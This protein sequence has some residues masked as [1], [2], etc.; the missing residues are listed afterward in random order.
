MLWVLSTEIC[1]SSV[2]TDPAPV[3]EAS[4]TLEGRLQQLQ[5]SAP[6]GEAL[7]REI[8]GHWKK[9]L[10]CLEKPGQLRIVDIREQSHLNANGSF[11]RRGGCCCTGLTVLESGFKC[12]GFQE[13]CGEMWKILTYQVKINRHT[14]LLI[15][16]DLM[17]ACS[18]HTECSEDSPAVS[19]AA[20]TEEAPQSSSPAS[21][22]TPNSTPA[23]G[24]PGSPQQNYQDRAE[25]RGWEPVKHSLTVIRHLN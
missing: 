2:S 7:V 12:L 6:D 19:G 15:H 17:P 11:S 23:P 10:E 8:S 18:F 16:I 21:L 25:G 9:H 22:M 24:A 3:L 14:C 1:F 4:H 5:S 20:A 13:S